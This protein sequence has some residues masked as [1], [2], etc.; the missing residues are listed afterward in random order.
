M[1]H[2]SVMCALMNLFTSSL[3]NL[4]LFISSYQY[5]TILHRL[6]FDEV[7]L[8]KHYYLVALY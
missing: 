4:Y 1:L 7:S 5:H 3:I 6:H 2:S 8:H